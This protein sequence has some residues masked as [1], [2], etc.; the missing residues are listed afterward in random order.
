MLYSS[1][2]RMPV[3]L[4]YLLGR[5]KAVVLVELAIKAAAPLPRT[6]RVLVKA[7]DRSTGALQLHRAPLGL[8][9]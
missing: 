9:P 8:L 5:S 2:S 6:G 1:G 7:I 4:K 3:Y